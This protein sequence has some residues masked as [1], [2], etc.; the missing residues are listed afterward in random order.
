M[1][2]AP[3]VVSL[4]TTSAPP[5]SPTARIHM[6]AFVVTRQQ[7]RSV[8]GLATAVLLAVVVVMN[9]TD[10]S[11]ASQSEQALPDIAFE[12]FDGDMASL[13]EFEGRPL[14]INFWASWC[15]AC[16][17]EL[18]EFEAAHLEYADEVTFV[19][20]ANADIRQAADRLAESV[21]LTYTLGDDPD[22]DMFRELGLFAMPSTI[23]VTADGEI[24]E[25]F[26]GQLDERALTER[27]DDLIGAS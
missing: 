19:G 17:A 10:R 15:P 27:I 22:G 12:R 18:P 7:R 24:H 14:V 26:G 4:L 3:A 9:V 21:G 16:V 1:V 25:V 6:S 13:A 8:I 11:T 5:A 23:F 2:D 20:I